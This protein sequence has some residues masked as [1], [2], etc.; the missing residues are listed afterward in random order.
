MHKAI[1]RLESGRIVKYEICGL[2]SAQEVRAFVL[3]SVKEARTVLC[4]VNNPEPKY[5]NMPLS[6]A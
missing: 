4:L 6:R 2:E 3:K 5:S 1:A